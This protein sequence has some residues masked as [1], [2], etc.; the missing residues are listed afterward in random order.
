[1]KVLDEMEPKFAGMMFRMS[2]FRFDLRKNFAATCILVSDMFKS[3][4]Q[5]NSNLIKLTPKCQ[6]CNMDTKFMH[7]KAHNWLYFS[8]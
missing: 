6:E 5:K 4:A 7:K 8:C 1:M 2:Y 3:I